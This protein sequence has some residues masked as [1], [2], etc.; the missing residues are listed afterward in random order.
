[1]LEVVWQFLQCDGLDAKHLPYDGG[2]CRFQVLQGKLVI[3]LR[4]PVVHD[5]KVHAMVPIGCYEKWNKM[6]AEWNE[7]EIVLLIGQL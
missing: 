6:Y 5:T 3:L 7:N 4:L 1:M 2:E